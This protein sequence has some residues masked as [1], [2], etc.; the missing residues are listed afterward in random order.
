MVEQPY[1]ANRRK[2]TRIVYGRRCWCEAGEVTLYAQMSDLSEGGL[3]LRT[4]APLGQGTETK[5]RF[6]CG[7]RPEEIE[8][9]AVVVWRQEHPTD[10]PPGMGLRFTKLTESHRELIRMF[11]E[12]SDAPSD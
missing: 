5:L 10:H 2:Y 9:E 8:A 11:I 4:L 3:F 6:S 7:N 12:E 1:G